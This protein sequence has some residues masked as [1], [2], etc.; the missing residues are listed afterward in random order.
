MA[1]P[2]AG[3]KV[4]AADLATIFPVGADD[5]PALTPTLTQ[6]VAVSKTVEYAAYSR[7]G[8]LVLYQFSLAVTS[9]GTAAQPIRV[10]LPPYNLVAYRALGGQF[11][12]F[13]ASA[14]LWYIGAPFFA[15][16]ST[17]QGQGSGAGAPFGQSLMTAALAAGDV[18]SGSIWYY[19]SS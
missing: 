15:T 1:L 11:A 8:D 5:W 3:A 9:A 6:S 19:T 16:A 18:V 17:I 12:V 10:S 4:L 2:L 14:G 13:D 7:I